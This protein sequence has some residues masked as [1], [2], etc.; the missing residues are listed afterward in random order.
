MARQWP[1]P[2]NSYT[3]SS[4]FAGRINPV[5]GRPENHSGTDFAAP[6]GTPFY[7]C[8]G[9]TVLHIG[10]A[11]GYGQWIVL[12]HPDSEGGGCSEYGHMWDAFATGLK[13]GQWVNAGQLIGY[14]GSNGQSTGPHLHLTVWERGYGGKRIDPEVWLAGRPYPNSPTIPKGDQM[15]RRN[16]NHRGDPLFLVDVLRLFGV[17]V[18]EF[19]NWR[20]RGHGDFNVIW[21]I[22]IHHTGGNNASAGSIANGSPN[23]AGPVSQIHLD[24]NAVATVVAAGIA[25][26]AGMG[27]WPGIQT[28]NANAVTIGVEANSDGRTPW[29]PAMLDAYYRICAAIC[30]YL[31]L[32]ASRVIGHK[33]WAAVQGKWD[34]G[35]INVKDFQRQVQRYIDNPP[36]MQLPPAEQLTEAGEPMAFWEEMLGSL[37]TPGKK[38]RRKDF[39]QLIDYHA[40]HAN[41]QSKRAADNSDKM[42]KEMTLLR[43]D[44]A[45]LTRVIAN[46]EASK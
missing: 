32:P 35:L 37:V 17:N 19:N 2:K 16:P 29:P 10:A 46:K 20:N 7:A 4:R 18:R 41:E 14:V 26:H 27:S 8:A 23:L 5:T 28:N 44:I 39:I 25:W 9:G 36:F 31:G 33:D 6:D 40:T 34:P 21:G 15:V 22:V 11:S 24:R 3:L 42:I 30:W 38:F 12:D 43:E 13:P 45:N 1:L